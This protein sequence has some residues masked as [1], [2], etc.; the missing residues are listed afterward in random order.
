MFQD[1][2]KGSKTWSEI[3]LNASLPESAAPGTILKVYGWNPKKKV[4]YID[5]L[6]IDFK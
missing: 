1:Q 3:V 2:I 4:G 5:D 6:A